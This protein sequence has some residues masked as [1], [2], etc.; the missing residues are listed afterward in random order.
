MIRDPKTIHPMLNPIAYGDE[1]VCG[2]QTYRCIND[3]F[4]HWL[5]VQPQEKPFYLKVMY[6]TNSQADLCAWLINRSQ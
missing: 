4:G 3:N 2:E 5:V 6:Q 1:V